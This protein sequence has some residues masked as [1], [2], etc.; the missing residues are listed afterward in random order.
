MTHNDQSA[1]HPLLGAGLFVLGW[2]SILSV[3]DIGCEV[4][5]S[6]EADA[7]RSHLL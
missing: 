1:F 4:G 2:E 6:A 3:A 5:S 7:E